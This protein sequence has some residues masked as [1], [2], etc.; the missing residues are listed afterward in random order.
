MANE[1]NQRRGILGRSFRVVI[2]G[3]MALLTILVIAHF[4][5]KYSGSNQWEKV[6][7]KDG[8]T[9]YT[10]KAPG[11]TLKR[12]RGVTHVKTTM[13]TAVAMMMQTSTEDCKS[14][15]PNC[16]SL[17]AVQPWNPHD[18]TY[19]QL[20]RMKAFRPFAPR[21]ALLKGRAS[22]DPVSKSVLVEFT[23]SPDE[24]ASDSCCYRISH[25][26]NT[27]RFTPQADGLVEVENRMNV[28]LG[29]PYPM[30]NR[31]IPN[32]LYR[33]LKRLPKQLDNPR[34]KQAKYETIKERT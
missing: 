23:A 32:A 2:T 7:D 11:E 14:W 3:V 28:D 31:F 9:I 13:N 6:I 33:Q 17:Q 34:F 27:W 8:V 12:I 19:I 25:M 16:T 30:F 20:Y 21:E 1:T 26:Q 18:L 24:V 29:L 4:T 5:W 15:F 10:L 22:Q